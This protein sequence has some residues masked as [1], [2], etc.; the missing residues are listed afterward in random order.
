VAV[1]AESFTQTKTGRTYNN[2]YHFLFKIRGDKIS[3]VKE[4]LDTMHANT[5]LCTP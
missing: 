4:Y 5:V 3:A 2:L 1:E